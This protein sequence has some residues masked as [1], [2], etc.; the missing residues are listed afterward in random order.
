MGDHAHNPMAYLFILRVGG[1]GRGAYRASDC[2][3]DHRYFF[4][5]IDYWGHYIHCW[6]NV[7]HGGPDVRAGDFVK[8]KCP[9]ADWDGSFGK[10]VRTN[11]YSFPSYR[12]EMT[13]FPKYPQYLGHEFDF[14][15]EEV[16]LV[17]VS[18]EELLETY[19][20]D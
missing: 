11:N 2:L 5:A 3:C 7:Y 10:I 17:S 4:G 19:E 18:K 9:H 1:R 6:V 15:A 13:I 12:V 20:V 16:E 8:V 14:D